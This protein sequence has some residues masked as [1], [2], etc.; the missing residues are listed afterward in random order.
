M[1]YLIGEPSSISLCSLIN[2][3]VGILPHIPGVLWFGYLIMVISDNKILISVF[4]QE[5]LLASPI[6]GILFHLELF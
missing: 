1:L 5:H 6:N 4:M 3:D 2:K